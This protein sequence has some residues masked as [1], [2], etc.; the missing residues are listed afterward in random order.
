MG[1]FLL[2]LVQPMV[3]RFVLPV[4]GGAPNVWNSAMLV[5]QTLLLG[6][7]LYAHILSRLPLR[8]QAQVHIGLLAASVLCLPVALADLPAAWPGWEML[9]VPALFLATIGPVF[10]LLSAQSSLMQRWYAA[11]TEAGDP[12]TLYAVSNVG[13]FAGLLVYPLLIEPFLPLKWQSGLFSVGY[14]GLIVLVFAAWRARRHLTAVS[15]PPRA[16]ITSAPREDVRTV[17]VW[18]ALAA[19]PSGL[20]LSTTTLLTTDIMAAPLLWV[21]P[22]GVYLLSF[23]LAFSDD[24]VW[25]N[26]IG[27]FAPMTLLVV[28][29]LALAPH[30]Q[31]SMAAALA[32]VGLQFMLSVTLHRQLYVRRPPV[33]NLTFFYLVM[34]GGGVLGGVFNALIAPLV[35]DWVYEHALMLLAAAALIAGRPILPAFGRFWSEGGWPIQVFFWVLMIIAILLGWRLGEVSLA[36]KEV[37]AF[38]LIIVLSSIGLLVMDKRWAYIC[39]LLTI[40]IGNVGYLTLQSSL[41]GLRARSYFGSYLVEDFDDG[42]RRRLVHGTTLH[43]EQWLLKDKSKEP[44]S[45]Y[46]RTSGIGLALGDAEED[47]AVGIV[48]LGAGT[49]A[50]YR[51]PGQ[52]WT[53]FE[54]DAAVVRYSRDGTFSFLSQCA[55]KARIVVG[56]ARIRL[57]REAEGRFD[58]LAVDA[59]SSD[60]IP[61]HLLT[62]EA[63][64][65]YRRVLDDKGV[66]LVHISN[67]YFNLKPMLAA[68]AEAG[69]WHASMRQ[70]MW[71]LQDGTTPSLWVAL[72]PDPDRLDQLRYSDANMPWEDLPPAA[73]QAWTDDRSSVLSVIRW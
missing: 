64:G 6:G 13:S 63:F 54:I 49:L 56:D 22:L 2:F 71:N 52:D 38:F 39:V 21:I 59:F 12:Y 53:F 67:R 68:L 46:G 4:L 73:M 61:V 34:A 55:P 3:A 72:S 8:R 36:Q 14:V 31:S 58:I 35:F 7:Y 24:G 66:L 15:P 60:A 27:Y 25:A 40:M 1:S 10:F 30:A 45:Y 19:V 51:K 70:D 32:T 9:W 23:V 62:T 48:G 65:V 37:E 44:T 11:N 42:R 17:F 16:D 43:G 26:R 18:L 69:N 28:S 47:A 20:M 33:E 5:F 57:A 50:C 41:A 29:W